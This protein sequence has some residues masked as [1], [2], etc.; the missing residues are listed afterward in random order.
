VASKDVAAELG[1]HEHTVAKWRRRFLKD[2]CEG[3]LDEARTRN[4]KSAC[5]REPNLARRRG[6]KWLDNFGS[7]AGVA[8]PDKPSE[9]KALAPRVFHFRCIPAAEIQTKVPLSGTIT[10]TTAIPVEAAK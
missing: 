3:R 5:G 2:R 4:R 7:L 1:L 10:L 9:Q 6:L 8:G